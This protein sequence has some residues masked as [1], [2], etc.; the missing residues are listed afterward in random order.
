MACPLKLGGYLQLVAI[1]FPHNNCF[2]RRIAR[3]RYNYPFLREVR[4][5]SI[6]YNGGIQ[7]ALQ[8]HDVLT[9]GDCGATNTYG[10]AI[11]SVKKQAT[12]YIR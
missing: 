1:E 4:Q 8:P 6:K 9:S 2:P 11:E 5:Q 10:A 7:E 12:D 3:E